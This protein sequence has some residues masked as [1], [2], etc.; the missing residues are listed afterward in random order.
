M[1]WPSGRCSRRGTPFPVPLPQGCSGSDTCSL[2]GPPRL[3][4]LD[5]HLLSLMT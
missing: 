4:V 3:P 1:L 2:P 5:G